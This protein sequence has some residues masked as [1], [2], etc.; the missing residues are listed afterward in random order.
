[1][2][3]Q[4]CNGASMRVLQVT[5]L[6][7]VAVMALFLSHAK[8]DAKEGLIRPLQAGPFNSIPHAKLRP[9]VRF[10]NEMYETTCFELQ[11]GNK[12]VGWIYAAFKTRTLLIL[13]ACEKYMQKPDA[14][15]GT[16]TGGEVDAMHE[17][18]QK[19]GNWQLVKI[20]IPGYDRFSQPVICGELVAYWAFDS[21]EY[22][23]SVYDLSTRRQMKKVRIG[24][25]DFG[26]DDSS[27]LPI[28]VWTASCDEVRYPVHDEVI[29]PII[30]K[31][32]E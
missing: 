22:F 7:A 31:L 16:F 6:A 4:G 2:K 11:V 24:R 28:P 8:A 23:A 12:K 15:A 14:Q 20:P 30:I 1:M 3:A 9:P 18:I 5:T 26:T 29:A 13:F 32:S 25:S 19:N 10:V 27:Y 17:V 21:N